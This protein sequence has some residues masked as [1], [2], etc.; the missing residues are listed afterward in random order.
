MNIIPIWGYCSV[1]SNLDWIQYWEHKASQNN[2]RKIKEYDNL[3]SEIKTLIDE[4]HTLRREDWS[5]LQHVE[6]S[7][8]HGVDINFEINPDELSACSCCN[9]EQPKALLYK[10]GYNHDTEEKII[11]YGNFGL[12]SFFPVDTLKLNQN[13]VCS[14][15]ANQIWNK[16]FIIPE[17][18]VAP[19]PFK[20]Y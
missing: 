9:T 15:C 8:E 14:I 11:T 18:P 6:D 20:I 13:V 3:V 2:K 7:L 5:F 17:S 1:D 4:K 10:L 19:N 16:L 12:G